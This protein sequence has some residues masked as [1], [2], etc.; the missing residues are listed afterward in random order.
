SSSDTQ[1]LDFKD[2]QSVQTFSY[3]LFQEIMEQENPVLSP[4]SAYLALSMAASGSA[5]STKTAFDTLLGE[6]S[7]KTASYLGLNLQTNE[8]EVLKLANSL[9]MDEQFLP[10]DTWLT[11]LDKIYDI[12]VYQ[13]DLSTN[14]A[15]H[16]INQWVSDQTNQ[17]IPN[18]LNKP[19]TDDVVLAL[20]NAIYFK[21]NWSSSFAA[22]NT[23]K[24]LFTLAN[25]KEINADMMYKESDFS[26]LQQD[27]LE[28][29]IL[30]Y[31]N[32]DLAFVAIKTTDDLDIRSQLSQMTA[33]QFSA[34]LDTKNNIDIQL[35]LPKF[36]VTF[37]QKLNDSLINL[38][39]GLA[40]EP[41][42]ADFS[43]MGTI[44]STEIKNENNNLYLKLVQQQAVIRVD[45]KGT[46]AAAVTIIVGANGSAAPS[47]D[48][49]LVLT[50]NKPF[51]YMIID[52]NT[53]LP[54]FAGILDT[55]K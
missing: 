29:V 7:L 10:Q 28:G 31:Q 6:N 14:T 54:V 37:D 5:G 40:F 26:Y 25:G 27:N 4:L 46:E 47:P 50:F 44:K 41:E 16:D 39:L 2:L 33:E 12:Q 22:E 3:A 1:P 13:T 15:M 55:P 36:E 9:W 30:P 51:F 43:S 52:T 19:F 32:S 48:E 8:S 24:E 49:P 23:H 45:E 35:T 18:F 42:L 17:L 38:G 20:L 21:A 11:S 34:L 53:N